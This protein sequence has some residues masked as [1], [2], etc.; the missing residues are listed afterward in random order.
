MKKKLYSILLII[1]VIVLAVSGF[2]FVK[3]MVDRH[4]VRNEEREAAQTVVLNFLAENT[5]AEKVPEYEEM[6]IPDEFMDLYNQNNDFIG[7]V[8]FADMSLYVCK[9][10]DNAYYLTHKFDGSENPAGMIF[11]DAFCV[12]EAGDNYLLHGHNMDNG[13]RFGK[14]KRFQRE[15]Y[16][17]A[18]PVFTFDTIR[19]KH[20]YRA[21]AVFEASF[22]AED[23]NYFSYQVPRF[24]S[25]AEFDSYIARAKELCFYDTGFSPS[26]GKPLLILSTCTSNDDERL[27]VLCGE[28]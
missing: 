26:F 5:G 16:L 17:K 4:T 13:S 9:G 28:I 8:R 21:V 25:E 23:D 6:P 15:A 20:E 2:L 1:S 12:F 18:N 10:R 7:I 19:G 22:S 24:R 27:V 14:L 11:L 3:T